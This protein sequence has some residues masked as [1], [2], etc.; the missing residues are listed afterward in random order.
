MAS[1]GMGWF[2]GG[3]PKKKDAPKNAILQ[4]RSTLDMLNKREKH[5]QVQMDDEDAKARKFVSTNK[6]GMCDPTPSRTAATASILH[7]TQD[8]WGQSIREVC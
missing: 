2:G 4:L 7:G 6:A 8:L 3:T 5:L 1:W